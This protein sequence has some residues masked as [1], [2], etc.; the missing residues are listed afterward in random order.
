MTLIHIASE[1]RLSEQYWHETITFFSKRITNE[2]DENKGTA[3]NFSDDYYQKQIH[4]VRYMR[5]HL[6]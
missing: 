1:R 4:P 6:V 2:S 3:K 5:C